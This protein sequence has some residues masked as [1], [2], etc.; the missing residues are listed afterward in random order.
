MITSSPIHG[1][2]YI[3]DV[4][5]SPHV[6]SFISSM[7]G[8]LHKLIPMVKSNNKDAILIFNQLYAFL[9]IYFPPIEETFDDTF[10]ETS[11]YIFKNN[12]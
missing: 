3:V 12:L 10:I 4:S 11:D 6:K 1:L 9:S 8:I 5:G 2:N 7:K